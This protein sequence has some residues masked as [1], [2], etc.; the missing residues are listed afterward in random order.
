LVGKTRLSIDEC[1]NG[2]RRF[3]LTAWHLR[4]IPAHKRDELWA[5]FEQLD[6]AFAAG[7]SVSALDRIV[8]AASYELRPVLSEAA[9]RC[10][11]REAAQSR[12]EAGSQRWPQKDYKTMTAMDCPVDAW[13]STGVRWSSADPYTFAL[14]NARGRHLPIPLHWRH[15]TSQVLGLSRGILAGG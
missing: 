6:R 4:S 2:R 12:P 8:A 15:H 10:Y 1:C 3:C 9:Q 11:P 7:A 5:R 13:E 14:V